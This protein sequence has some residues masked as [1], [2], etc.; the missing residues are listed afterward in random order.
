VQAVFADTRNQELFEILKRERAM[1]SPL[2][3]D[4]VNNRRNAE[5]IVGPDENLFRIDWVGFSL[6]TVHDEL[7]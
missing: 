4:Q 6:P 3:Q 7:C 2:T 1:A 5:K